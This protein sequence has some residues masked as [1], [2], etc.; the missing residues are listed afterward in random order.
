MTS[1]AMKIESQRIHVSRIINIILNKLKKQSSQNKRITCH[2]MS[3][4]IWAKFIPP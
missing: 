2:D 4:K 3:V 1:A